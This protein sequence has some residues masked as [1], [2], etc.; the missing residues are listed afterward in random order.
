MANTK[1]FSR[2]QNIFPTKSLLFMSI[3]ISL[4]ALQ[5]AASVELLIINPYCSLTS[6]LFVHICLCNV[7]YIGFMKIL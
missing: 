4:I 6:M 7:E 3:Y 5:V 2:S 1:T